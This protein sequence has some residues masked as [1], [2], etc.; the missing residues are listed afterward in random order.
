MKADGIVGV[1]V[2][3]KNGRTWRERE[4]GREREREREREGARE[5]ERERTLHAKWK[6]WKEEI[7][8]TVRIRKLK[9]NTGINTKD[10]T[11]TY[12]KQAMT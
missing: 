3:T 8:R 6:T 2:F 11:I 4:G 5:R 9:E 1:V 10:N 12:S 7:Q